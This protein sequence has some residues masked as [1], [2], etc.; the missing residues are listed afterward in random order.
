ML[1]DEKA[2][3]ELIVK[4]ISLIIIL[5]Q[6][7]VVTATLIAATRL[8]IPLANYLDIDFKTIS[9]SSGLAIAIF[10]FVLVGGAFIKMPAIRKL[11][12]GFPA[13][14][15]RQIFLAC[16]HRHQTKPDHHL[17]CLAVMSD[18]LRIKIHHP[19]QKS[20]IE[21]LF[22]NIKHHDD[23]TEV[24]DIILAPSG[25]GKTRVATLLAEALIRDKDT[26]VFADNFHYYDFS[27]GYRVQ[28]I[29]LKKFGSL[30]HLDSVVV[31]DNFHLAEA[32]TIKETTRRLLDMPL[33]ISERRL[34]FLAQPLENWR[35]RAGTEIRLL[36]HARKNDQLHNIQ[37]LSHA[38]IAAVQLSVDALARVKGFTSYSSSGSASIAEIQSAQIELKGSA[39]Q[40]MLVRIAINYL[41]SKK[42]EDHEPPSKRL[43]VVLATA[44]ALAIFKGNFDRK[45]FRE[46]FLK[47]NGQS[48]LAKYWTMIKAD[49]DL[50]ILSKAG[51]IPRSS[52]P[53]RLFIMHERLAEHLRD[54]VAKQDNSFETAFQC[55]LKWRIGAIKTNE[56]P[57]LHWLAGVELRDV[58]QLTRYFDRAMGEGNLKSMASRLEKTIDQIDS[59]DVIFQLGV[60][61]DKSGLFRDARKILA[62]IN[63][64]DRIEGFPAIAKLA[65]LEA[66]H[67]PENSQIVT[68]LRGSPD[69]IIRL[70]AEYWEI[71]LNAHSGIFDPEA[72]ATLNKAVA[73]TFEECQIENSYFLKN[74]VNR[75]YFD[76]LRH[77]HLRR[78]NVAKAILVNEATPLSAVVAKTD[79]CF[80]ANSL[81]YEKAHVLSFVILPA[82]VIFT[83]RL[84]SED[85]LGLGQPD[86][87]IENLCIR[88]EEAY[89][90]AQDE[91]AVFG[92][93]EQFYLDGD[94]LNVSIQK[95]NS[96]LSVT[97]I[98][99]AKYRNFIEKTG[100]AD[101]ASYP[102]VY[103]FRFAIRCWRDAVLDQNVY[104]S[105]PN[106]IDEFREDAERALNN[107]KVLD[108]NSGNIYGL[109]RVGFYQILLDAL[110]GKNGH[111]Q[112]LSRLR[113]YAELATRKGFNGDAEFINKLIKAENLKVGLVMN[114]AIFHPFVH[115]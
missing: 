57:T 25:F 92:N 15:K 84:G 63:E 49:R 6:T 113:E 61:L 55:A 48:G 62:S 71:H 107:I 95:P 115:Q 54:T 73:N 105:N 109:W 80:K 75:I 56:Q 40:K 98:K 7:M 108:E 111:D 11:A 3:L 29:F 43:V 17:Q 28:N 14:L 70:S 45:S 20:L 69:P 37:A 104:E 53:G 74:L 97:R 26:C 102:H 33:A 30:A 86:E 16:D 99:L 81:L 60:I 89:K 27:C 42:T 78:M 8:A 39:A 12:S 5:L 112:I 90:D 101:L 19:T 110:S 18:F 47:A 46:A 59:E 91:F 50:R 114:A 106:S 88:I 32:S 10:V 44:T 41:F 65:L 85:S 51:I 64:D 58:S 72:L 24:F 83:K 87:N 35:I 93:R 103:T 13:R 21:T 23:N 76:T 68:L 38:D 31:V 94:L 100:F 67:G 79:P 36:S 96:D 82:L 34:I 4:P 22:N 2:K 52:L 9:L 66:Q 77:I 1:L